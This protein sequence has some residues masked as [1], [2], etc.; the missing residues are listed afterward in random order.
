MILSTH[1]RL[2]HRGFSLIEAI[3]TI[4]II[5]IMGSIVVA[6]ISNLSRDANRILARQQQAT[7]Q[8][9]LSS[10]VL[11]QMRN[12]DGQVRSVEELRTQYNDAST[13]LGRFN[14]IAPAIG[15]GYLDETTRL[16]FAEYSSNTRIESAALRSNAQH[17]TLPPWESGEFPMALINEN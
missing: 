7:L 16:H 11:G 12:D 13:T 6:S 10:W 8:G 9:A 17:I 4:A 15:G 2:S 1:R 3:V 5:G 14:L